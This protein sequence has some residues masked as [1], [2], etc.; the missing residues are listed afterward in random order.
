MGKYTYKL[1]LP[2]KYWTHP[3]FNQ[4]LLSPYNETQEHGENFLRPPPDILE[5]EE[6]YE[7]EAIISHCRKGKGFQ[8]LI[9]WKGYAPSDDSW[10]SE[11][12]LEH[13][14]EILED[15]KKAKNL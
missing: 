2:E 13:S 12:S 8:Y 3:V 4:A 10:V 6:E 15:Y 14:E 9:R 5:G 1:K 7:V 11:K